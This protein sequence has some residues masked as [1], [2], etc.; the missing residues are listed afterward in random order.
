MTLSQSCFLMEKMA[1][2]FG[3]GGRWPCLP[4][5]TDSGLQELLE[6]ELLH[7]LT[8]SGNG[9]FSGMYINHEICIYREKKYQVRRIIERKSQAGK[10]ASLRVSN[11]LPWQLW[12][13]EKGGGAIEGGDWGLQRGEGGRE[14]ER[15]GKDE[16]VEEEKEKHFCSFI[17][18]SH[19]RRIGKFSS[20]KKKQK[21]IF[22]HCTSP[23][24]HP[25]R[26]YTFF[27]IFRPS[28]SAA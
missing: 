18:A 17:K 5:G 10:C 26:L 2:H 11:K 13:G 15:E 8:N 27:L 25:L 16:E 4:S 9:L 3:E 24:T 6:E 14:G 21:H 22:D 7:A 19:F 28:F 20:R 1:W 12:R 23:H